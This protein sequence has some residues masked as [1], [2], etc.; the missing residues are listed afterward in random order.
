MPYRPTGLPDCGTSG[1]AEVRYPKFVTRKPFHRFTAAIGLL[2][3]VLTGAPQ[4]TLAQ[5]P[6]A[7]PSKR[8]NRA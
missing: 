5:A 7:T 8:R 2:A 3:V 4:P 6:S 1:P